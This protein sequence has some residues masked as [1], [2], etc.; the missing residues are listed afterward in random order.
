MSRASTIKYY[1][2]FTFFLLML[3]DGQMTRA[4]DSIFHQN[5]FI[6]PHT[7]MLA[8]VLATFQLSRRYMLITATIIGVLMDSYYIGIIG[9]YAL[10]LPLIVLLCYQIFQY[11]HP[12]AF[13]LLL[14]VIIFVTVLETSLLLVQGVFSLADVNFVNF[15]T[16]TLGPTLLLNIALFL[17]LI[18]PFKKLF[19]FK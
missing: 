7:L 9:I 18:I 1:A 4:L 11:V 15:I 16:Q 2:P 8:L 3:L 10:C 5:F 17:I 14:A 6:H 13:T 12:N 19:I